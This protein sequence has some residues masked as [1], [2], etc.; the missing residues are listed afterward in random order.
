[1]TVAKVKLGEAADIL[2][3]YAFKSELFS[4]SEGMPLI[5]IRDVVRG[6]TETRYSGKFGD[7]FVVQNGEIVIGMDGNFNAAKWSG[8]PAL[9]NQRV[10]K[11]KARESVLNENYL[12][13]YLPN[14]LKKIEDATPF[15]TVKHLSVKGVR[16]IEIPLPPLP[17][18]I[19]IAAILD[20]ADALRVKRREALAQLDSLTQVI[21]IEMF[22]DPQK[23]IQAGQCKALADVVAPGRIVTYGI[24][25]AGKEVED[26]VPYVRTG[27]IKNG[28]ILEHQLARTSRDIAASYSRS[29]IAAGD[30][31]MSIR[32]TV[33]TTA[34]VPKSLEGANLTQGTARIAPGPEVYSAY[35]LSY[36][37][38]VSVQAWIQS[39]VK[40]AT[41]REITLG[42]LRKLPVFVPSLDLQS[43]FEKMIN[44]VNSLITFNRSALAELDTL[45]ASLL[46]RAF[47]GEL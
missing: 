10:C 33:G 12:F 4:D 36:L 30:I 31:V 2:S 42:R 26:G 32:A 41:F 13:H 17:E 27:D 37:R 5:R 39:Q 25:Q 24:V 7:E 9:L 23:P 6:F 1:M 8:G 18:Q 16:E 47:S 11:I 38:T 43:Q 29:A 21:F 22:G 15:V 14:A 35:L 28:E 40:G 34:L 44:T 46:H 20:H 19:R 3:G 45:F